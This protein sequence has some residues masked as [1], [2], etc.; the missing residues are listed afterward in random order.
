M[1]KLTCG[2]WTLSVYDEYVELTSETLV[3]GRQAAHREQVNKRTIYYRDMTSV[4]FDP[5]NFGISGSIRFH[6]AGREMSSRDPRNFRRNVSDTENDDSFLSN[7]LKFIDNEILKG[8]ED[9]YDFVF[10]KNQAVEAERLYNLIMSNLEKCKMGNATAQ[11][12]SSPIDE[13][14][15]LKELLDMGAI[16]QEEFE[17]KKAVFLSKI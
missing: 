7:I 16:S 14:K 15:K 5:A 12:S 6:W 9:G 2:N 3:L 8:A 4:D 1:D 11:Q 17:T 13:I 10:A